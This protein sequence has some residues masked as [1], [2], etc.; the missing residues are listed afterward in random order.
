MTF[1]AS[2]EFVDFRDY[3]GTDTSSITRYY[4][5][6]YFKIRANINDGGLIKYLNWNGLTQ[7]TDNAVYLTNM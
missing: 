2:D 5:W 1:S 7:E 6:T 3:V 4:T